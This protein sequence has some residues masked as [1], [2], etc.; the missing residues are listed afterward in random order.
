MLDSVKTPKISILIT[1]YNTIDFVKLSL[2]SIEQLTSS[3]YHVLINDNGSK[4]KDIV[5]LKALEKEKNYLKVNYRKSKY[6]HAAFAHG[7]ALNI[8]IDMVDTQYFIILDSDCILL[9]KDWDIYCIEQINAKVKII[10]TQRAAIGSDSEI[11]KFPSPF[12]AF[13]ESSSYKKLNISCMPENPITKDTCWQWEPKYNQNFFE[14]KLFYAKNTKEYQGGPFKS[15][16]CAE[17]YTEDNKLICNHFGRGSSGGV[18]K[19][20]TKW[21]FKI[22]YLSRFIRRHVALKEKKEWMDICYKIIQKE[23]SK[24]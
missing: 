3:S 16:Y 4:E 5:E 1:N 15:V 24:C 7:E 13:F 18:A 11:H 20:S 17:Y 21:W 14:S 6:E 19:Y 12:A 8:L 10:G 9:L 22:P 23:A 2:L